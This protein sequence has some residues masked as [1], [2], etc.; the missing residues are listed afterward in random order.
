MQITRRSDTETLR[1]PADW[2]TG[3]V[4]VDVAADP[5]GTSVEI[6]RPGARAF[7]EPGENHW[8]G[9]APDRLMVH[10]GRHQNDANGSPGP[11]ARHVT[12]EQYSAAPAA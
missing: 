3:D 10:L 8:H 6:I 12:D 11:G 7:F 1:D 4:F 5:A 2:F 9:A